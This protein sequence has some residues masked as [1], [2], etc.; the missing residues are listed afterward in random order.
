[1]IVNVASQC[2]FISQ[3]K[4]LQELHER[5]STHKSCDPRIPLQPF[6]SSPCFVSFLTEVRE[7]CRSF[8]HFVA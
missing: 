8:R 1:M 7:N 6:S 5:Y 3:Y 2:G 4:Q